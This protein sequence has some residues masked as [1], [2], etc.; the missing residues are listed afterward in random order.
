MIWLR[1]ALFNVWFFG[2]TAVLGFYG[3]WIRWLAPHLALGLARRWAGL[4][5]DG[6]HFICGIE[7]VV[8]GA[9]HI[10]RDGPALIASEHQSAFDTL[11][12]LRL[13]P[14]VSY[15]FKAELARVPLFGPLLTPSG[16]ISVD[17]QGGSGALTSLV[18]GAQSAK[19]SGRQIVIFPE[20]T[21]VDPGQRV[22]LRSGVATISAR[23]ALPIVPVA[24]DSGLFWGRRSFLKRSGRLHVMVGPPIPPGLPTA[25]ALS[26]LRGRLD[27]LHA[28]LKTVDNSVH[29]QV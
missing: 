18:R 11:I 25:E 15:I 20:G 13:V 10:P 21:R 7:V 22:K 8:T 1:S 26:T 14:R 9:E 27:S 29:E 23:T 4:V 12:W 24:T 6:A 2:V 3:L 16:Q 28:A 5:L 19:E 17:R